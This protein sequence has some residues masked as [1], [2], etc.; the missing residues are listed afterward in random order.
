VRR[1][2]EKPGFPRPIL[3]IGFDV[4]VLL[5]LDFNGDGFLFVIFWVYNG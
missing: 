4:D 5:A 3:A 2:G 1:R